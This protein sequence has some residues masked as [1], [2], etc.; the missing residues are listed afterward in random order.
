MAQPCLWQ[1]HWLSRRRG[2]ALNP[3]CEP[4][5]NERSFISMF[6][7]SH[8]DIDYILKQNCSEVC[9][10]LWNITCSAW[11]MNVSWM[12]P[13]IWGSQSPFTSWPLLPLPGSSGNRYWSWSAERKTSHCS[14][15]AV[16]ELHLP[17]KLAKT[18]IVPHHEE[19][20]CHPGSLLRRELDIAQGGHFLY[21]WEART[22]S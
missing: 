20:M 14:L 11:A 15:A 9:C 6:L 21:S 7:M 8:N 3:S 16:L 2:G 19:A 18:S 1:G 12:V 17:Q 10:L 13:A 4:G 22:G 5:R